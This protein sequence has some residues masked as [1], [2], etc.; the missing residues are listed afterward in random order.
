MFGFNECAGK[1]NHKNFHFH[2]TLNCIR[3]FRGNN[4]EALVIWKR[5][6]FAR[7]TEQVKILECISKDLKYSG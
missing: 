7:M 3:N 4:T 1:R 5:L 2:K 6:K